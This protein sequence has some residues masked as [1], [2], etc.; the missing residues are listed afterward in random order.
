MDKQSFIEAVKRA[1]GDVLG[2]MRLHSITIDT[3]NVWASDGKFIEELGSLSSIMRMVIMGVISK[4]AMNGDLK[5]CE[6]YLK[7]TAPVE[8]EDTNSKLIVQVLNTGLFPI[9]NE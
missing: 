2:I 8:K 6:L 7:Q 1:N 9:E 4:K 5:A 3:I